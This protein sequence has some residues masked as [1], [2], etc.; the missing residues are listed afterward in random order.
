MPFR[1]ATILL[2]AIVLAL[3]VCASSIW[4]V[5]FGQAPFSSVY[6]PNSIFLAKRAAACLVAC[7]HATLIAAQLAASIDRTDVATDLVWRPSDRQPLMS[8][9]TC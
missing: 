9:L 8:F 7:I 4:L 1:P 5:P 3:M 2:F 6:G